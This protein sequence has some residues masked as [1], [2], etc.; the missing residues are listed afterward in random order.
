MRLQAVGFGHAAKLVGGHG[1]A[2]AEEGVD[3]IG[4]SQRS[5]LDLSSVRLRWRESVSLG[6]FQNCN[7]PGMNNFRR[8]GVEDE[9]S[10]LF[11]R[12]DL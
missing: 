3:G 1:V 9:P 12:W 11:M 2:Q 7:Q 10:A 4:R 5:G 6:R 8:H